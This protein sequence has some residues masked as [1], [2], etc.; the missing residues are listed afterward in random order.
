MTENITIRGRQWQP[1][2]FITHGENIDQILLS[3]QMALDGGCKWIQLRM[4]N[5]P[6][7][8]VEAAAIAVKAMCRA[9]NAVLIIDDYVEIARSM[10]LDGVHLGMSDMPIGEARCILGDKAIIGGTANTADEARRQIESGADYLGIGPFR[11]TTTKQNLSPSL[12]IEGYNTIVGELRQQ[13][14][15]PIVAIG[16]LTL[17]DLDPLAT[18]GINGVAVS[19]AILATRNPILATAK[20]LQK[21]QEK[22]FWI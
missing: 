20:W 10:N 4:K 13:Y 19:G 14:N 9:H 1:L 3:A 5:T 21:L 17:D 12:G 6:E 8:V 15:T 7:T 22:G 2:Q 16:G 18:T 11:F